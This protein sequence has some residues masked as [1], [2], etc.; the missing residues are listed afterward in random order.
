VRIYPHA[1]TEAEIV[2]DERYVSVTAGK[3]VILSY[4]P[5]YLSPEAWVDLTQAVQRAFFLAYRDDLTD[6]ARK[7]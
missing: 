6:S 3:E 1:K 7:E 2:S 4:P 5:R